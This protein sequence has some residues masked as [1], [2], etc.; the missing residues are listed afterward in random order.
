MT[1]SPNF[2]ARFADNEVTCMTTYC[3]PNKLDLTR[4]VRLSRHAHHSRTKREPPAILAARF[5]DISGI[6]VAE[7]TAEQL[8]KVAP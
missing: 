4:G 6:V 2:I 3:A 5:E 1:I 7:Y 8:A